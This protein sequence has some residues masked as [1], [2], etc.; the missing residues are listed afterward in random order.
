MEDRQ[1]ST[2]VQQHQRSHARSNAELKAVGLNPDHHSLQRVTELQ[3]RRQAQTST[4]ED[5]FHELHRCEPRTSMS[6]ADAVLLPHLL[7]LR[8][9][10]DDLE[11]FVDDNA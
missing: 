11:V 8:K 1:I 6:Q 2:T 5:E 4:L 10:V 9:L 7:E 3:T